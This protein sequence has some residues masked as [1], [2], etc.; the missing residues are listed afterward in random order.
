M[1]NVEA[2]PVETECE[3]VPAPQSGGR[4]VVEVLTARDVPLAGRGQ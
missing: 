3:H 2:R 1:S 4:P